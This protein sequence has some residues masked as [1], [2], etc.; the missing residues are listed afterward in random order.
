MPKSALVVGCGFVGVPLARLLHFAGWDTLGITASPES[1]SKLRSEAFA[2]SAL[3]ITD[4]RCLSTISGRPYDLIVHCASSGKGGAGA[5]EQVYLEGTQN[6]LATLRCNHYIFASSTSVYAQRDGSWVDEESE[7]AP[8]RETGRI[9]LETEAVA[10]QS[11]GTVG[12]LAGLYGPGRCAPLKKLLAGE[13]IIE[14][15]GER[16]MNMIHRDDAAGALFFLAQQTGHGRFNLVDDYS[17]TQLEWYTAVCTRL[18]K[19]LPA[20]GPRD[21]ERKRGWT[22]KRVS[23]KKLRSLGWKPVYPTFLDGLSSC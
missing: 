23:N 16:F 22:N 18:G 11:G 8:T 12:R 1:A 15:E 3:D 20:F 9:L 17:P 10:L 4:R 14:G 7:A 19:P 6:L 5:Y 21:F 2:V 13:A